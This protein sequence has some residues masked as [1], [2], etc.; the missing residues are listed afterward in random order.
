[1][2]ALHSNRKYLVKF[3]HASRRFY[4]YLNEAKINKEE[5]EKARAPPIFPS[6]SSLGHDETNLSLSVPERERGVASRQS[7]RR[8]EREFR[9]SSWNPESKRL[10]FPLPRPSRR[11]RIR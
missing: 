10:I 4:F 3:H 1:M 2:I 11:F 6:I 8:V 9:S 7:G 5:A